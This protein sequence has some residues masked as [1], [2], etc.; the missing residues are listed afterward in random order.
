M[1]ALIERVNCA[2]AGQS[3]S[4]CGMQPLVYSSDSFVMDRVVQV[5]FLWTAPVLMGVDLIWA[6]GALMYGI[7]VH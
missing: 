4:Q 5:D 7:I 1:T 3:C 6:V 2:G